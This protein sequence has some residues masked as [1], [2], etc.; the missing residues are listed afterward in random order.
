MNGFYMCKLHVREEGTTKPVNQV[1]EKVDICAA[2][3]V[4]DKDGLRKWRWLKGYPVDRRCQSVNGSTRGSY[5]SIN[6]MSHIK[7][8]R[9][10]GAEEAVAQTSSAAQGCLHVGHVSRKRS[11]SR[12]PASAEEAT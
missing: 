10:P 7:I 1:V 4:T 3:H 2:L 9:E 6:L 11:A 12:K 8:K 5:W